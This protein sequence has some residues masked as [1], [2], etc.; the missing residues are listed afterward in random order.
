MLRADENL[1]AV[2]LNEGDQVE[3][4]YLPDDGTERIVKAKLGK[5]TRT[6]KA[7]E[8]SGEQEVSEP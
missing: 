5:V 1:E 7:Q 4:Y 6:V 2:L 8:A 3:L